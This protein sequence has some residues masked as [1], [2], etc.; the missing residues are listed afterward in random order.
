MSELELRKMLHYSLR[1]RDDMDWIVEVID[2]KCARVGGLSVATVGLVVALI[3]AVPTNPGGRQDG[4]ATIG[5][6]LAKEATKRFPE[7]PRL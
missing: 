1:D 3:A 4:R 6:G 7:L 5:R 2:K